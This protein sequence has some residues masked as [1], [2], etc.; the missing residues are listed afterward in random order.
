MSPP[1]PPPAQGGATTY[2]G[3]FSLTYAPQDDG[4]PD[5]GEVVWSWVAFEEDDRVGK[6]RP[7]V[8]IGQTSDGRLAA[9][10]LSTRD[11]AGDRGWISVGSG[12][13]DEARRESWVRTDRLLVVT[14]RSVRREGAVLSL[15]AFHRIAAA[16][17]AR[18]SRAGWLGRLLR[19][20]R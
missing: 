1:E 12:L 14:P 13:W 11:H 7:I 16:L 4:E 8:I 3:H 20:L 19:R 6:D 2:R 9:L 18:G 10:M 17:G 15:P 5:P